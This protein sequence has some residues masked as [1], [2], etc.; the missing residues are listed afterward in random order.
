M[1]A[2]RACRMVGAHA[3]PLRDARALLTVV[4]RK[5]PGRVRRGVPAH[6][7]CG[8]ASYYRAMD[9]GWE[10]LA[11]LAR[12]PVRVP[13]LFIGG[14]VDAPIF[15]AGRQSHERASGSKISG[16]GHPAGLR[17]LDPT[18]ASRRD[19]PASHRLRPRSPL[20]EL[21]AQRGRSRHRRSLPSDRRLLR[22]GQV[23]EELCLTRASPTP[24]V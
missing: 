21:L 20:S 23:S 10:E 12:Q 22:S 14:E 2:P 16:L 6:G 9:E 24:K 3:R 17:P 15:W 18:G 19:E 4:H 11:P 13:A 8:R 1:R 7:R 5:R